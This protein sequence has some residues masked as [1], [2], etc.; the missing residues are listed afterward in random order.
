MRVAAPLLLLLACAIGALEA[1][2]GA[3]VECVPEAGG[4]SRCL[5]RSFLP[6]TGIV[7]L[8]R[9]DRDCRV[10]YYYGS[11]TDPVWLM[12]PGRMTTLPKPEVTWP[13]TTLAQLRFDCGRPCTV[14]YF[15]EVKRR[16]MSAPRWLVLDVDPRRLLLAAA[17]ERALVVRQI[18]SG[19]EVKRIERDWAPGAWLGDAVTTLHFDP[20]GRLS[21]TWLRG[22]GRAPV[23]ERLSIPSFARP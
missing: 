23:S 18:F 8:C 17:E 15:F 4:G 11:P 2:G 1:S 20:D 6:S 3:P 13:T 19:R 9:A 10:G 22:P 14:S 16:R 7:A 5:Y 12:P 21:L